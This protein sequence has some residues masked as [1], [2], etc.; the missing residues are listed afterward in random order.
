MEIWKEKS[1]GMRAFVWKTVNTIQS[2][3]VKRILIFEISLMNIITLGSQSDSVAV[4]AKLSINTFNYHFGVIHL[5][6]FTL[7]RL[8]IECP[9]NHNKRKKHN[10]PMK[11]RRKYK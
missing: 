2:Q 11:T 1:L 9:S 6:R 3:H 4:S 10:E 7:E 8:S 5:F